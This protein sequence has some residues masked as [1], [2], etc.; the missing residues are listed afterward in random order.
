MAC[1]MAFVGIIVKEM[2]K[3][4]PVLIN[5]LFPVIDINYFLNMSHV[6]KRSNL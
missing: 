5:I 3:I 4:I 1:F 6:L 2:R